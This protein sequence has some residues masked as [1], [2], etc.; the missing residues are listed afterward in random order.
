MRPKV[1]FGLNGASEEWAFFQSK[2]EDRAFCHLMRA[3]PCSLRGLP[4]Q[5]GQSGAVEDVQ[6]GP[7]VPCLEHLYPQGGSLVPVLPSIGALHLGDGVAPSEAAFDFRLPRG[8]DSGR[9][10]KNV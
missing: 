5:C 4:Q 6:P 7:F 10:T 8:A 9:Y 1:Y 3:R 2:M